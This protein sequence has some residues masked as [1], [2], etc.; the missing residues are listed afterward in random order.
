MFLVFL[1]VGLILGDFDCFVL[2][3]LL[4]KLNFVDILEL[5]KL[6]LFFVLIFIDFEWFDGMYW[7]LLDID[8]LV[9][10]LYVVVLFVVLKFIWIVNFLVFKWF[11]VELF[12]LLLV[13]LFLGCLFLL[14]FFKLIIF[15]YLFL[16]FVFFE[17]LIFLLIFGL[18]FMV[19]GRVFCL[20]ECILIFILLLLFIKFSNL[21]FFF[22]FWF[23]KVLFFFMVF[24]NFNNC[25]LIILFL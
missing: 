20:F 3:L 9:R 19:D 16:V 15:L 2:V 25:F 22:R 7:L 6:L 12:L 23:S 18:L 21:E 10:L 8:I 13:F 5:F 17:Y 14:F 24:C 1:D 11:L 4:L